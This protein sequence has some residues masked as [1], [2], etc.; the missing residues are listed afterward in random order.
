M[1][2]V[3]EVY[4]NTPHR[5][6]LSQ[7]FPGQPVAP[8]GKEMAYEPAQP[9]PCR[10]AQDKATV[11]LALPLYERFRPSVPEG[12]KGW[13]AKGKLDLG[14]IGRLAKDT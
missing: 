1:L 10:R 11:D 14:L 3:R 4:Q 6:R 9:S 8:S 2:Y 7:Q 12:K 13:G 5:F